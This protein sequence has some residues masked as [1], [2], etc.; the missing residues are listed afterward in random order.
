MFSRAEPASEASRSVEHLYLHEAHDLLQA[1]SHS[2]FYS[3]PEQPSAKVF[4]AGCAVKQV[5]V[6]VNKY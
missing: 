6:C 1:A 5:F 2:V 3:V 4:A